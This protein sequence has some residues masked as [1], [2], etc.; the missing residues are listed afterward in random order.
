MNKLVELMKR[1]GTLVLAA[2]LVFT[3][4]GGS[5]SASE[6]RK[7]TITPFAEQWKYFGQT[8]T[9][10]QNEH[11]TLSDDT[12]IST[13]EWELGI[14]GE[15]AGKQDYVIK[16]KSED[17]D[18]SL[19][20]AENAPQFEVKTYKTDAEVQTYKTSEEERDISVYHTSK[21]SVGIVAPEGYLISGKCEAEDSNWGKELETG[22]LKEG[23]NQITYYLRSNFE[24]NTR[25]AID[26][27]K[28]TVTIKVDSIAPEIKEL[29]AG[30][31]T[32]VEAEGSISIVGKDS[33]TYYYMVV[34]ADYSQEVTPEVV[35]E[36]VASGIGIVG[37][38]RL[39]DSEEAALHLNGLTAETEYKIYA[40]LQDDAG[41]ISNIAVSNVFSTDKIALTGEVQV[42][43]G[44]E[45]GNT[46]TA[47]PEL[48]SRDP[49]ELSYQWYRIKL[50]EDAQD[51]DAAYDKT[52]G[53]EEDVLEAEDDADEEEDDDKDDDWDSTLE[54]SSDDEITTLDG[55]TPVDGATSS[56]YKIT[57]ADI[58][59]RLI[60]CVEAEN[61]S[62]YVAGSTTKFVPKLMPQY[63]IPTI[64]SKVYSPTRKLSSIQLPAQWSW[65]DNTIVPVY[66][67]SGYR[68]KFVPKDTSVYQSVIVRVKV[69]VTKKSL[70]KSMVTVRKTNMYT[71]K[72]IKNNFT[73]KYQKKK[74]TSSKDFKAE[75]INNKNLGKAI[76]IITGKGNYKGTVKVTYEIL[77]RSLKTVTCKCEKVKVYKGKPLHIGLELENNTVEM[78]ENRDYTVTYKNNTEVGKA[79]VILKGRGNYKGSRK[80]S[81][82]II[83]KKPGIK[84][85]VKNGQKLRLTLSSGKNVTG[86]YVYVSKS[87][88]F[89]GSKTQK[90]IITG[91]SFGIQKMEKGTWYIRVKAYTSKKGKIY[92]SGYSSV[93]KVKIK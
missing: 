3:S 56:T 55:A 84:K 87:R 73:I 77:R 53:A 2:S 19:C 93:K 25:K 57:R 32:D 15:E 6:D 23:A 48:T 79:T 72:A 12:Y 47:V 65:V 83:P 24:D 7:I 70:K 69:P 28:K 33:A 78:K 21:D 11:Y 45:V 27:N 67:N 92:S 31:S 62:G 86:Y 41:N 36:K 49:G 64:K 13:A 40:F 9:F 46:L 63:T 81:F 22:E 52:G 38:G 74:L 29:V 50:V 17:S 30:D 16:W 14:A 35:K 58:G 68:A 5:V 71:G 85:T 54:D 89:P 8:R 10:I 43:G 1:T 51:R 75:Y 42:S 4:M 39:D 76:V 26:Q 80:L 37:F 90:Y 61:Y 82:S 20:L 59:C 18:Q 60:A 66:G 44:T 88:S 91:D 34:P